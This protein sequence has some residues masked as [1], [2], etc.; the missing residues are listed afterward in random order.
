MFVVLVR[1]ASFVVL[2]S[3][4]DERRT[5]NRNDARRPTNVA[6]RRT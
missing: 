4:N 6:R 3:A 1:G 5:T 2:G